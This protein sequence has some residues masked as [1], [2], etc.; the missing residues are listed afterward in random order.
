MRHDDQTIVYPRDVYMRD[1]PRRGGSNRQNDEDFERLGWS[2]RIWRHKVKRDT[3][4]GLK[5]MV[6]EQFQGIG[7]TQSENGSTKSQG[8]PERE[9]S[10]YFGMA[11]KV[12]RLSARLSQLSPNGLT[13]SQLSRLTE[14]RTESTSFRFSTGC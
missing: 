1:S 5:T 11:Q 6:E 2:S 4:K 7:L 10:R 14:N 13:Q 3:K 9:K 12:G 8:M